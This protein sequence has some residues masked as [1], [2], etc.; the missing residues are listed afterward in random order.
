MS[1]YTQLVKMED[2][3]VAFRA[4]V[5]R[6]VEGV[7]KFVGNLNPRC[8]SDLLNDMQAAR[9]VLRDRWDIE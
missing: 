7:D 8:T 3:R 1:D 6:Y 9:E 5:E 2:G 4:D